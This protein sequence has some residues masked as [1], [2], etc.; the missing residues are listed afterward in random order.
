VGEIDGGD[1]EKVEVAAGEEPIGMLRV[2][3][4]GDIGGIGRV[5]AFVVGVTAKPAGEVLLFERGKGG[6]AFV[7]K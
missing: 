3:E 5:D 6:V 4:A 7:E 2:E 1:G